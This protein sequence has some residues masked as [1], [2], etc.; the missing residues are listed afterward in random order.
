MTTNISTHLR[1]R[2]SKTAGRP[3]ELPLKGIRV[4]AVSQF[5]AGPYATMILAELG[6]EII[7]I[8]DPSTG[9]D[10]SRSVPPYT[11]EHDSLYFQS[12]NRNKKSLTLNIKNREGRKVFEKLV[13]V[14]HAILN[15][16]RGDQVRKLGL[17]YAS[18]RRVNPKIVC[19]SLSGFGTTG[20]YASEPGYDY[21][22]QAHAGYMS[23]TGDPQSPPATCGVSVIDHAAGFA[24][25]L[26]LTSAVFAAEKMGKGRDVEVSLIDTAFS[27]LTYLAIWNLNREYEPVRRTGSA[28]QSLV[29]VQTFGTRDGHIVIFCA[30]ESFW[31]KL[32]KLLDLEAL[33]SDERFKNFSRRFQNR[34]E[35]LPLLQDKLRTRTT[36]EWL[37][38]L[39]GKIPCAPVNNLSEAMRELAA[40][41]ESMII[42][43]SH[44]VFGKIRQIASPIKLAPG[45]KKQRRAPALGE[46]TV[47][48]LRDYLGY[49]GKQVADLRK[50]RVI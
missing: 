6:A 38:V 15:N 8:E 28:H 50:K 47:Q 9:G 27:M 43:T 19:C 41:D 46:H 20:P 10:V 30:K 37:S 32:C 14:S 2:K 34:E 29:P 17:N 35:L 3:S 49:T 23:L 12:F 18:L 22:M 40:L 44:R 42:E 5:G 13:E 24:S 33:I 31:Q 45:M 48:I 16:L 11:I 39:R 1:R 25:A 21:L 26:G 36:Q 7:K 4:L